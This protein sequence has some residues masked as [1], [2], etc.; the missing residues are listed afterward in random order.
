MQWMACSGNGLVHSFTIMTRAVSGNFVLKPPYVVAL[1]ELDEGPRMMTN[2]VGPSSQL[3]Q[4]GDRVA[5]K[6]EQRSSNL[7]LP[8]FERIN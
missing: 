2:I 1:I 3:V 4:I 7:K 5:M 6:L 8:L